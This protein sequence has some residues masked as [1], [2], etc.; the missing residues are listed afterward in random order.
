MKIAIIG[1]SGSGKSTLA[2]KL[3]EIYHAEVLHLDQVQFLPRWEERPM[4]EKAQIVS[5]FLDSH[6][7][8]VIDGNYSKLSYDRRMQ[9]ADQ[10]ILLLFGRLTCLRRVYRR[11]RTY[12]NTTRP[13]VT[14][15]C[16]EKL[17]WEFVKWILWEGRSK[18]A[19]ARYQGILTTYPQKTVLIK[20]PRQLN[21]FWQ[22]QAD[23]PKRR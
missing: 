20:N 13:D 5:S 15:G 23:I 9:E 12:R 3:G 19:R 10:I 17:D 8:W 2:R 7:A 16:E 22:Q 11:Y 4:A 6:D 14:T 18:R 1:Y 21:T